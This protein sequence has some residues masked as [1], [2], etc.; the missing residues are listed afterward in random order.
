[1]ASDTQMIKELLDR[2]KRTETKVTKVALHFGVD[3]GQERPFV[4]GDT[5]IVPNAKTTLEEVIMAIPPD[6]VEPFRIYRG[7]VFIGT[8]SR[9]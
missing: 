7:D 6:D 4:Q 3:A 8:F 9:G 2:V 1:M 5:I